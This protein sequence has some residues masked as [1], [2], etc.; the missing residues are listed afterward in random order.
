MEYRDLRQHFSRN[1]HVRRVKK[2]SGKKIAG[3]EWFKE[4]ERNKKFFHTIVKG[5]RS[6]LQVNKIQNEGGE[7]LEDQEDIEGEAVDFYNK[8]FT[9]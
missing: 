8:Q 1:S 3:M 9:M 7:W 6:R 2:S 5:R 4:E